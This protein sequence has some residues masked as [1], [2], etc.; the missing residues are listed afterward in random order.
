MLF[1]FSG[2]SVD[3]LE[4]FSDMS[5]D[6]ILSTCFGVD[7][8]VQTDLNSKLLK[9]IRFGSHS[10]IEVILKIIPFGSNLAKFILAFKK[11]HPTTLEKLAKSTIHNRQQELSEGVSGRKDLLYLMLTAHETDGVQRLSEEEILAQ[12]FLFLFIG[13][14][15]TGNVLTLVAYHLA[16]NPDAQETLRKEIESA[17]Q[18]NKLNTPYTR[19]TLVT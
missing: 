15:N 1:Y 9:E 4:W 10:A 17:V 19:F 6:A 14:E 11:R 2:K 5:L 13:H 8:D 16:M 3:I 18:V 12:A 7:S